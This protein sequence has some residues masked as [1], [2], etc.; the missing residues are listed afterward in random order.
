MFKELVISEYIYTYISSADEKIKLTVSYLEDLY[1]ELVTTVFKD[2][3]NYYSMMDGKEYKEPMFPKRIPIYLTDWDENTKAAIGLAKRK[4]IAGEVFDEKYIRFLVFN[5]KYFENPVSKKE[6][7]GIMLHELIHVVN[8]LDG[9]VKAEDHSHN[10]EFLKEL[11]KVE[12]IVKMR[13]PKGD[14][15]DISL[16]KNK[17]WFIVV[18]TKGT[19]YKFDKTKF[20][21]ENNILNFI[22]EYNLKAKKP[23]SSILLI[24]LTNDPS[25]LNM[26]SRTST[27]IGTKELKGYNV[28]VQT[29][30]DIIK[31]SE[32]VYKN[33]VK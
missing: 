1:T 6:I 9:S 29:L 3:S 4:A 33:I 10:K 28:D 22:K 19:L 12:K 24:V 30:R 16:L 21:N 18:T 13:I 7:K 17:K 20:K 2:Y 5:K 23:I 15:I 25:T 14:D 26:N 11:R 31:N 8:W 27:E 32:I